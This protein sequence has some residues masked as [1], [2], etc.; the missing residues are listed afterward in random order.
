MSW[1]VYGFD[2]RCGNGAIIYADG[3]VWISRHKKLIRCV[4]H[5]PVPMDE[6]EI[7]AARLR[8]EKATPAPEPVSTGLAD[9]LRQE[10]ARV[11]Q[12]IGRTGGQ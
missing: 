3:P 11:R 4:N 1:T 6:D 9:A 7:A 10:V 8:I 2:C 5:A 12:A